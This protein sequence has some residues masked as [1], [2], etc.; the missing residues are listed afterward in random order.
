MVGLLFT[1]WVVFRLNSN[2]FY[3]YYY[4]AVGNLLH[5]V[6]EACIARDLIDT[7]A[8]FWPGYVSPCLATKDQNSMLIQ[9]SP[10]SNFMQGAPLTGSLQSALI[11][12]PAPR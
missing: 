8:Y 3:I 12:T 10:W 6:V 9:D 1:F 4:I 5:L 2:W 11:A 7:S